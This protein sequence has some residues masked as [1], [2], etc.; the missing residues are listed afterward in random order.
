MLTPPTKVKDLPEFAEN[1]FLD[2]VGYNTRKKTEVLYDGKQAVIRTDTGEV[3]ED[4]LAVARIRQ[5]DSDQ[6][7]KLYLENL[8]LFFELGKPAQ[9]VAEFVLHQV[10]RR[11]IGRG[12]VLLLFAE[13]EKYFEGRT[14]GNR[15]MYM[16][17]QQ[18]LAQKN[19]IAKSP[20][21]NVWWINPAVM[22]NGDRARFITEIRRTK[23]ASGAAA[24]EAKGQGR[25][26]GMEEGE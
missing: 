1:P 25:L 15:T 3:V 7:V 12:E 5:V 16:R 11:A 17:G 14:G 23:K 22:F 18:E 6:F 4:H 8:W 10:G 26:P 2:G 9:R 19:L 13:Y 21:A 20:I 24:L